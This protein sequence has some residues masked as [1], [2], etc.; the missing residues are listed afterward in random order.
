M[1]FI[2]LIARCETER[3][4]LEKA[5]ASFSA[6]TD[7]FDFVSPR[8][9]EPLDQEKIEDR[10]RRK[11]ADKLQ[12]SNLDHGRNNSNFA[13]GCFDYEVYKKLIS[14]PSLAHSFIFYISS[15]PFSRI[16]LALSK[17]LKRYFSDV[18]IAL[19]SI[20]SHFLSKI[21]TSHFAIPLRNFGAKHLP[22]RLLD[23]TP[24][25]EAIRKTA[26][27]Y[28]G[29]DGEVHKYLAKRP[30]EFSM[31]NNT[32]GDP[33]FVDKNDLA[34]CPAKRKNWHGGVAAATA[35]NQS[36][37]GLCRLGVLYHS[38]FHYDLTSLHGSVTHTF[39]NFNGDDVPVKRKEYVNVYPNDAI[40]TRGK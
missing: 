40:N 9:G 8:H 10:I 38:G 19:G 1:T 27:S 11:F 23:T 32:D 21:V 36:L 17:L 33:A 25:L 15:E 39:C 14:K 7:N 5:Q 22:E 24:I 13:I 2:V 16:D 30:R 6:A 29:A 31:E 3:I 4:A 18:K 35:D 20:H 34:F 12:K 37:N 28:K 26:P